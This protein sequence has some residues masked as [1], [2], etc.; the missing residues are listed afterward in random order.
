MSE[1]LLATEAYITLSGQMFAE[2]QETI[3]ELIECQD[4]DRKTFLQGKIEG[5]RFFER[6]ESEIEIDVNESHENG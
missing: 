3:A 4:S 6:F 1:S 2:A 5:L